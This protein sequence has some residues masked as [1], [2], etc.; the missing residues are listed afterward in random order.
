MDGFQA[1][2]FSNEYC[3]GDAAGSL[4]SVACTKTSGI[5]Y[6]PANLF[7]LRPSN[8][9]NSINASNRRSIGNIVEGFLCYGHE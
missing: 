4:D 6:E 8:I 5:K 7:Q 9:P 3:E 1:D 2:L